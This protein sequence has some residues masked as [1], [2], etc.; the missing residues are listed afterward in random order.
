M[1]SLLDYNSHGF[2][3]GGGGVDGVEGGTKWEFGEEELGLALEELVP[4]DRGVLC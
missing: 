1:G 2:G 3:S 4:K